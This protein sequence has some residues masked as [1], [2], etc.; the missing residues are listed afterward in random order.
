Q[1]FGQFSSFSEEVF[2]LNG[3]DGYGP[4]GHLVGGAVYDGFMLGMH[5]GTG[6]AATCP[7]V[8]IATLTFSP[9]L[10][11]VRVPEDWSGDEAAA[12]EHLRAA[13]AS[14]SAGLRNVVQDWKVFLVAL[15]GD[16][17]DEA[18]FRIALV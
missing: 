12:A 5:E 16:D 2:E 8:E 1:F 3:W 6:F 13:V 17:E 11:S 14:G 10:C 15:P 7:R 18:C 4:C 9:S